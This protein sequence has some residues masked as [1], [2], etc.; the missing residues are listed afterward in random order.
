MASAWN[1][2]VKSKGWRAERQGWRDRYMVREWS[3]VK[4]ELEKD[5]WRTWSRW[6]RVEAGQATVV[7]QSRN[8]GWLYETN[9]MKRYSR[10]TVDCTWW[11]VGFKIERDH[12]LRNGPLVSGWNDSI[13]DGVIHRLGTLEKDQICRRWFWILFRTQEFER[14][15]I[16]ERE[17]RDNP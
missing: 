3:S 5:W 14:R 7:D 8:D 11:W 17:W 1:W 10:D 6:P 9:R 13:D 4:S 16:H 2:G 15:L 12:I